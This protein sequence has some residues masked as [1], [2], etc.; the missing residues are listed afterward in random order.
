[1]CINDS[2]L[3]FFRYVFLVKVFF[4]KKFQKDFNN[5]IF[6][7]QGRIVIVL[8]RLIEYKKKNVILKSFG[9]GK[10]DDLIGVFLLKIF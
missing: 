2:I 4:M 8:I 6:M 9:I 3:F 10:K 1:M 7:Y 5:L